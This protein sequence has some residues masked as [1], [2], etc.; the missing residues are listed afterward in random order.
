MLNAYEMSILLTRI[1]SIYTLA[2]AIGQFQIAT[3]QIAAS[4]NSYNAGVSQSVSLISAIIPILL[5]LGLAIFLWVAANIIGNHMTQGMVDLNVSSQISYNTL[6]V[7][8]FSVIGLFIVV[9][10][11]PNVTEN[12]FSYWLIDSQMGQGMNIRAKVRMFVSIIQILIGLSLIFGSK[13]LVGLLV[14]I[15]QM[16]VRD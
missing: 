3:F 4:K 9:Q 16:G 15:R 1:L 12:L 6:E 5:L 2:E 14:R 10:A 11:I 13:G 8:G 7:I